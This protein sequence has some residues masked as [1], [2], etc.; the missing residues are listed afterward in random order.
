ML[1]REATKDDMESVATLHRRSI[2][3]LCKTHYSD[4][5]LNE[6]TA[7]LHG[8]AYSLLMRTHEFLVAEADSEL[9]GFCVFDPREGLLNATYVSPLASRHGVGRG[10][11]AA[12]E[13]IARAR[14]V[15]RIQLN[16]TLNAVGF[17]ERLG[18]AAIEM[19]SNTLPTGVALPCVTMSKALAG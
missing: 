18:Y 16:A 13:A 3:D 2:L 15:P 19:A 11:V 5:Q 8:S 17:Y 7:A 9:A 4:E 6:W 12:V 14:G 1:V 10:L